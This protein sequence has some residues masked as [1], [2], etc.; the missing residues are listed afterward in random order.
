MTQSPEIVVVGGGV[1]G[2]AI[3]FALARGGLNVALLERS[4]RHID[5]VRGEWLSP[6]GVAEAA[7][8][9]LTDTLQAAGGQYLLRNVG[10]DETAGPEVAEANALDLRQVHPIGTGAMS[11]GHPVICDAFDEA[12]VAAGAVLMRGV[13]DV[14]VRADARP[15]IAFQYLITHKPQPISGV[16]RA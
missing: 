7:T 8:L 13:Q 1:G 4:E 6:W 10:Y 11:I 12:A 15:E 16:G 14:E 5:R 9:G 3:A 2:G